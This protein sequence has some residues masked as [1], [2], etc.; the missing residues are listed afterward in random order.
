MLVKSAS[1]A[2]DSKAKQFEPDATKAIVYVYR[3]DSFLG[4]DL[5]SNL[6]LNNNP[7]AEGARSRF[8]VL[9]LPP[10]HYV[11]TL[12]SNDSGALPVLMHNSGKPPLELTVEPGKLYFV[13]EKWVGYKGFF[14]VPATREEA[15]PAIKKGKL[16]AVHQL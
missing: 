13:H 1:D 9:S 6:F 2:D 15:E 10:G 5:T 4:G 3:D 11:F 8:N 7:V 14:L 16:I 12:T